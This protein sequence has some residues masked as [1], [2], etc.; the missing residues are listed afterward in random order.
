MSRRLVELGVDGPPLG[1]VPEV[2]RPGTE[3]LDEDGEVDEVEQVQ[4]HHRV[5]ETHGTLR[6]SQRPA[7][8]QIYYHLLE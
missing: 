3:S 2:S 1:D 7:K 4:A 6:A 8:R 5:T